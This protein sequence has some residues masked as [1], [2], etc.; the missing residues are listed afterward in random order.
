MNFV[1]ITVGRDAQQYASVLWAGVTAGVMA[2]IK[3]NDAN[4]K[5]ELVSGPIQPIDVLS[6]SGRRYF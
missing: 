5:V 4:G 1:P 6:S 2:V 3:A